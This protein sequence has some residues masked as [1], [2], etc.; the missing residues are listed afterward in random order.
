[1][2]VAQNTRLWQVQ[3]SLFLIVPSVAVWVFLFIL[4]FESQIK[5]ENEIELESAGMVNQKRKQ[6]SGSLSSRQFGASLRVF[7]V[8]LLLLLLLL[9]LSRVHRSFSS[10]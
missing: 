9:D 6:K 10:A 2:G 1:V 7:L 4:R 5:K 8:V 3:K